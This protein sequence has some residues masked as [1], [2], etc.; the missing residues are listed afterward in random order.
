MLRAVFVVL[1]SNFPGAR[2]VPHPT[3]TVRPADREWSRHR[4]REHSC[5][6]LVAGYLFPFSVALT[7]SGYGAEPPR[8]ANSGA[9]IQHSR[10]TRWPFKARSKSIELK[11][12]RRRP[13]TAT[14]ET[15][16]SR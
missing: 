4:A 9:R 11:R 8:S 7:P 13:G 12:S 15:S 5:L 14:R 6:D 1:A 10:A 16:R 2:C 3:R